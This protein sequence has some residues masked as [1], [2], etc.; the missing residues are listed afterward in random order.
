MVK[1]KTKHKIFDY[2]LNN[3]TYNETSVMAHEVGLETNEALR[4][5]IYEL[6]EEIKNHF[7]KGFADLIESKA[8]HGYKMN[9][10]YKI[11]RV[12]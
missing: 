8:R 4:N 11:E 7:G 9:Q 10:N 12:A 5:E 2:L 6:R 3:P 1:G